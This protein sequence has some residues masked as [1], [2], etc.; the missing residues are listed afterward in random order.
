[1]SEAR[2]IRVPWLFVRGRRRIRSLAAAVNDGRVIAG[3]CLRPW[4]V[5]GDLVWFDR[6]VDPQDGD[7]VVASMLYRRFGCNLLGALQEI[8]RRDAVK[9]LRIV[10][11]EKFLCAVDGAVNADAHEILG[12]VIAWHR[13][14][15]WRR[16]AVKHMTFDLPVRIVDCSAPP[17]VSLGLAR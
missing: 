17:L 14:G 6:T 13:P 11:G 5:D 7:V 15:W 4:I 2:R 10:A 9:Q 3:D 8:Q 12:P 1:M 16:P